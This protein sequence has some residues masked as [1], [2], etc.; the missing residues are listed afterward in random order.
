MKDLSVLLMSLLLYF[1]FSPFLLTAQSD[2]RILL[3][4]LEDEEIRYV[5]ALAIYPE[6]VRMAI[7]QTCLFPE[8]SEL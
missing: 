7:L 3:E 5:D 8:R 4:E 1:V 2:P 6:D